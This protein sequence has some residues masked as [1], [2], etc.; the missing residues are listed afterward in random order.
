MSDERFE[1]AVRQ[2]REE[3]A[4][5]CCD[6]GNKLKITFWMVMIQILTSTAL[7]AYLV[8]GLMGYRFDED[9]A[10]NATLAC[11]V[12]SVVCAIVYSLALTTLKRYYDSF[13]TA[14]LVYVL[15]YAIDAISDVVPLDDYEAWISIAVAVLQVV[16]VKCLVGGVISSL[17]NV[18]RDLEINWISFRK[19]YTTVLYFTILCAI[20]LFVPVINVF[21]A[22]GSLIAAIAAIVLQIWMIILIW[23]TGSMLQT[24]RFVLKQ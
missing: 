12:I 10:I 14:G 5:K 22:L 15:S 4:W 23:K 6:I 3:Q 9:V 21:A 17:R 19:A 8:M 20:L 7:T 18:D 16:H 24:Y 13:A 11:S 2:K 1:Q